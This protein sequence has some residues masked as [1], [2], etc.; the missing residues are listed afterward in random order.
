MFLT[1]ETPRSAG[2]RESRYAMYAHTHTHKHTHTKPVS[3]T[4]TRQVALRQ[5]NQ[6][7]KEVAQSPTLRM[8]GY[9]LSPRAHVREAIMNGSLDT[10]T[11]LPWGVGEGRRRE[12]R[13]ARPLKQQHSGKPQKGRRK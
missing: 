8:T 5:E 10:R 12:R 1:A 6:K 4:S 13:A 9:V 3:W 7:K 2:R 11:N